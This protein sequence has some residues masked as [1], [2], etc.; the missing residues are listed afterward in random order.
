MTP[1]RVERLEERPEVAA[2]V[3]CEGEC[4]GSTSHSLRGENIVGRPVWRC[5][6]CGARRVGPS[7]ANIETR[8]SP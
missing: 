7:F 4:P 2:T 5:F 8:S 1:Q 6:D 3:P